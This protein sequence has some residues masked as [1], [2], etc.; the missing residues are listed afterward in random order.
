MHPQSLKNPQ[1]ESLLRVP[2]PK[3]KID[4]LSRYTKGANKIKDAIKVGIAEIKPHVQEKSIL[5]QVLGSNHRGVHTVGFL[6]SIGCPLSEMDFR[7]HSTR[8]FLL[9]CL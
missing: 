4:E 5:E 3:R 9:R 6:D 8:L 1:K 7:S 2:A